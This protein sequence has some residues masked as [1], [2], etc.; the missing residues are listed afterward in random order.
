MRTLKSATKFVFTIEEC[1]HIREV[2]NIIDL[3]YNGMTDD[4]R[5]LDQDEYDMEN[6]EDFFDAFRKAIERGVGENGEATIE[7]EKIN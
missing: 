6:I 7:C 5:F 4:E 2:E 1:N 3:I